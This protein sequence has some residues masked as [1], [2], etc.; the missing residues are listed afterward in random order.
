MYED[1]R[2]SCLQKRTQN[3]ELKKENR[4]YCCTKFLYNL[5]PYNTQFMDKCT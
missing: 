4:K 5:S 3:T 2:N 1:K